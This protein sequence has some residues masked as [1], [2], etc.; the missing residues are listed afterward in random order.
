MERQDKLDPVERTLFNQI[1]MYI[2]MMSS[3]LDFIKSKKPALRDAE[4]YLR[5]HEMAIGSLLDILNTY[6]MFKEEDDD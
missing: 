5:G 6:E 3:D 2:N 4:M 1:E